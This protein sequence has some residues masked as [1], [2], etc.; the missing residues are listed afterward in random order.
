MENRKIKNVVHY[1]LLQVLQNTK[2]TYILKNRA[3]TKQYR[4]GLLT[5]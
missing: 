3:L 5:K 1:Q 4:K 2:K